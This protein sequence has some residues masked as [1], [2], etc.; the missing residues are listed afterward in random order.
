MW[1]F[2][3][4][5]IIISEE[6]PS[7]IRGLKFLYIVIDE[8]LEVHYELNNRGHIPLPI[9]W[10]EMNPLRIEKNLSKNLIKKSVSEKKNLVGVLQLWIYETKEGK[11]AEVRG[12]G[13]LNKF[14]GNRVK[15]LL[16]L[17]K[18]MD[19]F[20]EGYEIKCVEASTSV[21]PE[22]VMNRVG[23]KAEKPSSWIT[24]IGELIFR[25]KHYLKK[26]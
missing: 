19:T 16:K 26:Y 14:K 15:A 22:G 20:C 8:D 24:S 2:E 23:F 11:Y 4:R 7:E 12:L 9:H 10:S 13:I 17:V 1:P 21:I 6:V 18:A 3:K 25:Q 5:E